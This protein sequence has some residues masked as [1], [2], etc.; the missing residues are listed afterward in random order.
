MEEKVK[1]LA[2]QGEWAVFINVLTLLLFGTILFPNVDRLVDLV[3]IDTFLAYHH[4]KESPIIAVLADTY[5]MFNLRCEKSSARIICCMPALYVWL[6]SHVF[7]HEGRSVCPLQGHCLC[8]KKGKANWEELLADMIGASISWFP[9]WK[10]GGARV[11]CSCEGFPNVP[12][13]GTRHCINYNHV[14]AIRQL[15]YPMRGAPSEEIITPI[16]VR[17]FSEANA[18]ILQKIRKS[19]NRV[20]RKDKE[21]R[22]S[23]NNVIDD[24]HKWLKSRTQ[25]ITWILKLKSLSGKEAKIPEETEEV[26]ALKAELESTSVVKK[27]LK[28]TVTRVKKDCD[29]LK[30]INMTTL[31][32]LERETKRARKKEWSRNKFRGALWGSSNV[33]KLRKVERDESRMESMV[34]EDKLKA[35]QS[36]S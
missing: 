24:Y 26:Q 21:L 14:L 8:F 36:L 16:I 4:C 30:D 23:S 17:G 20:E 32:A 18:K 35:Y 28:T 1:A 22:G 13:M 27:K 15:G 6:V 9:R 34:L 2:S 25:G 19:W 11:L 10:E 33:L 12:L 5:D 31:K 7:Y 3:A 29:E